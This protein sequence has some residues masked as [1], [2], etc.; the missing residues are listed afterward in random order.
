MQEK[1]NNR[2]LVVVEFRNS[3]DESEQKHVPNCFVDCR[4]QEQVQLEAFASDGVVRVRCRMSGNLACCKLQ[5]DQFKNAKTHSKC[6]EH[7]EA[8]RSLS[9]AGVKRKQ[10]SLFDFKDKYRYLLMSITM[11]TY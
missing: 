7:V 3:Q 6:T 4:G 5:T 11:Y 1:L 2:V 10:A 9:V 8:V